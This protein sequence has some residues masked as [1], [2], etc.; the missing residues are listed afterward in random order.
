MDVQENGQ[1]LSEQAESLRWHALP[2]KGSVSEYNR[3]R[4][5]HRLLKKTFQSA[6]RRTD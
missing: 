3:T 1:G 4:S 5:Q 6:T 2:S